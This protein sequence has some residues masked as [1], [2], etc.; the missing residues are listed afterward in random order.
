[1][2][3][4]LTTAPFAE[5]QVGKHRVS[6]LKDGDQ[7]FPLMLEAIRGAKRTICFETYIFREDTIG[8][9]FL[10]ALIERAKAGIE[11]SLLVDG[12]GTGDLSVDLRQRFRIA[13]VKWLVFGRVR[14]PRRIERWVSRLRRRNHRKALVVDGKIA[15]A[16]GLN[17]SDEYATGDE[18]S[19]LWRDT[20]V[21]VEGH[22]ALNLQTL[23]LETWKRYRGPPLDVTRYSSPPRE[24][25]SG[26]RVVANDFGRANKDIRKAYQQAFNHAQR[27]IDIMNAYF[28]PPSRVLKALRHAA[29]KGVAVSIII[30][31]ATDVRLVLL[32][33][34]HLYA[35]LLR[36]GI[37]IYEW[38]ERVL[39]AKTA[40]I[41]GRWA[42][43]GS[44]NLDH[45]SL[46]SNL[47]V[48]VVVEDAAVGVAM[49]R[50]FEEDLAKSK[51]VTLDWVRGR[52]WLERGFWWLAYQ[53][54][55]W[56]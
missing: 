15:F 33:A 37:R 17:I 53:V 42:T 54:R 19:A 12:W 41:D 32:A 35:R 8:R 10:E 16:G 4:A 6:I 38:D 22:A 49:E 13:G 24:A 14:F 2:S 26:V 9:R 1:M 43:I 46:H 3:H 40:V 36:S 30:G 18:G 55:Y 11:V 48:N 28:V 20:H 23:F 5:L 51:E 29:R 21:R 27:R 45:L 56:L 39:H 44:A 47:E 52:G 25:P 31:A 34:R 50:L 7:A